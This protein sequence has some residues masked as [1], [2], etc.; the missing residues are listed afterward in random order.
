[1]IATAMPLLA[2]AGALSI[3]VTNWGTYKLEM[4]RIADVSALAGIIKYGA[5]DS[6]QSGAMAGFKIAEL[7]GV[8]GGG[9]PTWVSDSQTYANTLITSKLVSG[10]KDASNKAVYVSVTKSIPRGLS[11]VFNPGGNMTISASARAELDGAQ[12]CLVTLSNAAL[13]IQN[14]STINSTTCAI[15]SNGTV[16]AV[17]NSNTNVHD[18]YS[19][20][21][22]TAANPATITGNKYPNSAAV[23][24]PYATNPEIVSLLS[25]LSSGSGTPYNTTKTVTLNPGHFGNVT[26]TNSANV[27]LNPGTYY[28][29]GNLNTRNTSTLTGNGVTLVIS[30]DVIFE[31]SSVV[32]L[33]A[34][35]GDTGGAIG[36]IMMVT[37]GSN[38]KLE[39]SGARNL[40]GVIYAPNATLSVA[41]LATLGS[42]GCLQ[43]IVGA[44]SVGN[45]IN[46]SASTCVS[47]GAQSFGRRRLLVQ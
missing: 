35:T 24:D 32:T 21:N 11:A 17:N 15:W 12:P 27:T 4:Q 3:E 13:N 36:G 46:M 23:Q 2:A 28:I 10:V 18:I 39:N 25:S 34:A 29:H 47:M 44:A 42:T 41:N 33:S 7:S 20:G 45:N 22:I 8:T 1:M 6:P 37:T 38:I 43:Y 16:V 19:T 40:T 9:T 31:Q 30:G 5:T 14:S 26:L